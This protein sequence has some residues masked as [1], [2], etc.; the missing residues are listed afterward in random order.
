MAYFDYTNNGISLSN[1][2]ELKIGDKFIIQ[3]NSTDI[4]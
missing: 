4:D 3:K 2:K 1:V